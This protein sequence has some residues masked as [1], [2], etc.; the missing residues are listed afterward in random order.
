[1][2]EPWAGT[3]RAGFQEPPC[4]SIPSSSRRD[5]LAPFDRGERFGRNGYRHASRLAVGRLQ[6]ERNVLT[7]PGHSQNRGNRPVGDAHRDRQSPDQVG[8]TVV[9]DA[10]MKRAAVL[11]DRQTTNPRAFH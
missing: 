2:E 10:Q 4:A 6:I 9:L 1:M 11:S 3:W 5:L 8:S 7:V